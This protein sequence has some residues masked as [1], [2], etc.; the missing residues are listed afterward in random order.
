[1]E[2]HDER[3]SA[4]AAGSM[5]TTI[6]DQARLW[7]GIVRGDGLSPASRAE[8]VRPQFPITSAHQFPTLMIE[9]DPRNA[10]I[11]LSAGLAVV[12]FRDTTGPAWFKGGHNDWTGNMV[13][14]L[15][16]GKHCLVMMANDVRAE[17][18]YPALARLILGKSKMPWTWEYN[19]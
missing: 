14:G 6:A 11:G 2:P 4:S 16:N 10:K 7:A 9:T 5:D 15:E 19:F 3:G 17:R 1:M 18:I 8:L 12:T 13:I